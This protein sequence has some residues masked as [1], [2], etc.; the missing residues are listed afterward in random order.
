CMSCP[1]KYK[2]LGTFYRYYTGEKRAPIPTIFVGGNHEASNYL[3][4]LFYGGWV[5]PNIYYMGTSNVIWYGP[6]RIGGISGIFKTHDYLSGFW[7][8][9]PFRK[10]ANTSMY[11]VREF[12]VEKAKRICGGVDIF[13]S[14]DWP[15]GIERHGDIEQLLRAKPFFRKEVEQGRLGSDANRAVLE[16]VRPRWW[17][18]AHLHVRFGATL[19][20]A[21]NGSG[22]YY[23]PPSGLPSSTG[24]VEGGSTGDTAAGPSIN[25]DEI[26]LS[27]LDDDD[28]G[29]GPTSACDN[30]G[31]SGLRANKRPKLEEDDGQ[32]DAA[33]AFAVHL[34]PPAN[35]YHGS[36]TTQ[37]LALDKC[38]GRRQY[39]EIIEIEVPDDGQQQAQPMEYEFYYDPQWLAITKCVHPYM[40]T[41]RSPARIPSSTIDNDELSKARAWVDKHIKDFRIPHNFQPTAPAAAPPYARPDARLPRPDRF[42]NYGSNQRGEKYLYK[43]PQ[44]MQYCQMLGITDEFTNDDC[45]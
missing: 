42:G 44:T 14:H 36:T 28:S 33:G 32:S 25:Q 27:D 1:D 7:E 45:L 31:E 40:S 35:L 17:F 39:L 30:K 29:S 10:K 41:T 43:N 4:E 9:P 20:W 5:A 34:P 16:K 22:E 8:R 37:F 11:H 15:E 23:G 18:S 38:L 6:L 21:S 2:Q 26:V 24:L 3:R 19:D 13:V 12:D